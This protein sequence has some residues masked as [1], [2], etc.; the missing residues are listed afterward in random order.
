[1]TAKPFDPYERD[2]WPPVGGP[3]EPVPPLVGVTNGMPVKAAEH[4]VKSFKYDPTK[5]AHKKDKH[6]PRV[7]LVPK[8]LIFGAGRALGYGADSKYGAHNYRNYPG[9]E[10]SRL[11]AS[12]I[13]HLVQ[14]AN[15][16]EFDTDINPETGE[17]EGSGLCHLDNAAAALGMLMDTYERIKAGKLP[18][19]KDDRFKEAK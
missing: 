17:D 1:M 6:K 7:D 4:L 2:P 3:A 12:A 11:A 18:A 13:R 19:E 10:T 5:G 16:E 8:A 9:L 14:W 15:G